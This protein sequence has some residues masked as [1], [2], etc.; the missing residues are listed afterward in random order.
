M[1][2]DVR[3]VPIWEDCPY[4]AHIP[5]YLEIRLLPADPSRAEYPEEMF[6]LW[7]PKYQLHLM[8]KGRPSGFGVIRRQIRPMVDFMKQ[9]IARQRTEDAR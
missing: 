4:R 3:D 2:M 1:A 7:S 8:T 9:A 5:R 6:F